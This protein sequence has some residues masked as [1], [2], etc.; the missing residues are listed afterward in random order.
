MLNPLRTYILNKVHIWRRWLS[1]F[2]RI[3]QQILITIHWIIL[4]DIHREN[5][6]KFL[7]LAYQKATYLINLELRNRNDLFNYR[8]EYWYPLISFCKRIMNHSFSG[9]SLF[10]GTRTLNSP[11]LIWRARAYT[12]THTHT[13]IYICIYMYVYI[14]IYM[15]V[16]VCVCVWWF[17]VG[18][19]G[20]IYQNY[21]ERFQAFHRPSSGVA[22]MC[23]EYF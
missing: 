23:T 14:Y 17:Q 22:C 4:R 9:C 11:E 3:F 21:P 16:C 13:Y 15:C 19:G 18:I 5:S 1:L 8:F 6:K 2:K 12:H 20:W 7:R 10:K